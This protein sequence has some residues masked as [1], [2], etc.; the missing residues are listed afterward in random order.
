M[1]EI[2]TYTG[3]IAATNA[4]LLRLPGGTVLVDAPEGATAWLRRQ[5]VRVDVLFLT[6]QHF[7]HVMDA[8]AVKADHGCHV[9]AFAPF[10]RELTLERL[11]GMVTGTFVE[12]PAFEVDELLEGRDT[13][14][15]AGETW[16]L[17]H[18]PGHSPDSVCFLLACEHLLFGGDVLFLDGIGRTDFPG[19]STELLLSGIESK[20][21]PL[22]DAT[23]VFPGH[24]DETTI[25]RER[26]ENPF[27]N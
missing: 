20:L 16:R 1:S 22:P 3:G 17:H 21:L 26:L 7:D 18:V 13:L 15:A 5:K 9:Y 10:S 6:H 2:S 23:R 25:G 4:H 27:L 14:E 8:A 12:V 19:G 11:F 24:G